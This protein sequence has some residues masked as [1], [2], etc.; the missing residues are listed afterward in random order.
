MVFSFSNMI[1]V[2]LILR[3]IILRNDDLLKVIITKI[4]CGKSLQSQRTEDEIKTSFNFTVYLCNYV[5]KT[6]NLILHPIRSYN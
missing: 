2:Q 6:Q 4:K 5:S 1:L 3:K